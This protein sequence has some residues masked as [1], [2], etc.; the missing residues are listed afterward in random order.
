MREVAIQLV[1]KMELSRNLLKRKKQRSVSSNRE[2]LDFVPMFVVRL[3]TT[4]TET[5][6]VLV[7]RRPKNFTVV[8]AVLLAMT[9]MRIFPI[10]QYPNVRNKNANELRTLSR[11]NKL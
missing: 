7:E 5:E 2:A 10:T 9:T 4:K 6:T 1:Y 8:V 3:T 11:N